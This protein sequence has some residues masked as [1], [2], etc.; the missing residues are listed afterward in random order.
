MIY[1]EYC[2]CC[3]E[4]S[5]LRVFCTLPPTPVANALFIE[6]NFEKFDLTLCACNSCGHFQL[7]QAPDPAAV[8]KSYKY[9]SGVS[10][11]FRNHFENYAKSVATLAENKH[12]L[13][14]G[15]NDGFLL[16]C[17]LDLGFNVVGFEPSAEISREFIGQ[18]GTV[19]NDFFDERSVSK[20]ALTNHFGV[21]CANNV[22]AHIPDIEH[23]FSTV[24]TVLVDGGYLVAEC[25]DQQGIV[26]GD[27]IDNVYHEHIDYY[28]PYSFSVLARRYG[29]NPV[30]VEY[31]P[32]HGKSFRIVCKKNGETAGPQLADYRRQW[33]RETLDLALSRRRTRVNQELGSDRFVCYG[34]AAKAVTGFYLLELNPDQVNMFVDDNELK[35]GYY[36]PGTDLKICHSDEIQKNDTVLVTAWNVFDDIVEKL[37]NKGHRGK[38]V[39]M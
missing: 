31:V 28:S 1:S 21:V 20:H 22:L 27:F 4:E 29:L 30:S 37:R 11:F 13:E 39:C 19:I 5:D 33:D 2:R 26:S 36:F 10:Q 23:V 14:I 3:G 35:Q 9:K 38:V 12:V 18:K 24:S 32:T 7:A 8:F 16:S 34:A 17:F 25:G 6:P 15:S